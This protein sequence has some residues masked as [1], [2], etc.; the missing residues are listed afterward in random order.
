MRE[1]TTGATRGDDDTKPHYEGY[2]SPVVLWRFGQY[3]KQHQR[4]EDGE[5]RK[6]DNWQQGMPIDDYMDSLLRHQMHVWLRHRGHG[7]VVPMDE[8]ELEKSDNQLLLDDL[9][10]MLF[11]TMGYMHELLVRGD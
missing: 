11:N 5:L 4:Q 2:L 1:Y 6:A 9:C 8:A 3:M 7:N 10:A